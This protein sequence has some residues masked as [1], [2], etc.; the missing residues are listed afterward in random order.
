[1]RSQETQLTAFEFLRER[2]N[3]GQEFTA[4]EM[5]AATGWSES[6][7]N[8][9]FSKQFRGLIERRGDTYTV[10]LR[11]LR[12]KQSE[13]LALVT[14]RRT[15]VPEYRHV[16]YEEVVTYEFLL[17]LT[18][19]DRLRDALDHLFYEDTLTRLVVETGLEKMRG[20]LPLHP[21]ETD[22]SYI[23]R[24]P[25][26]VASLVG[27]YSISH[28]HG[29]FR[30]GPLIS[31][32]AAGTLAASDGRYL[33]DETTALVRFIV[34]CRTTRRDDG[35]AFDI[36]TEGTI[37]TVGLD[38]EVARIRKLFFWFFVEAVAWTIQGED[39]IWLLETVPSGRR[40]FVLERL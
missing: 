12:L 8:T 22:D 3:T 15:I 17:P 2:A 32:A 30:A 34:P 14:Q 36:D 40:L 11:F 39:E 25:S 6:T 10:L 5:M 7:F 1:V 24:A 13:F 19:E 4:K 37:A 33:V 38:T 21:G 18:T 31:R 16:A 26:T 29:R 9:Y 23:E 20:V 27:G 35:D 28:V